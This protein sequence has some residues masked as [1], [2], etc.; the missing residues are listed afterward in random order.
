MEKYCTKIA[1][2]RRLF[3]PNDGNNTLGAHNHKTPQ[4]SETNEFIEACRTSVHYFQKKY[5]FD[6]EKMIPIE[7]EQLSKWNESPVDCKQTWRWESLDVEHSYVPS[8]YHQ[9]HYGTRMTGFSDESGLERDPCLPCTPYKSTQLYNCSSKSI[10]S[11]LVKGARVPNRGDKM[12]QSPKSDFPAERLYEA[13]GVVNLFS[14]WQPKIKRSSHPGNNKIDDHRSKR[15]NLA[16]PEERNFQSSL[17]NIYPSSTDELKF[18][19]IEKF[20]GSTPNL[21]SDRKEFQQSV[22]VQPSRHGFWTDE[23][24][25]TRSSSLSRLKNHSVKRRPMSVNRVCGKISGSPSLSTHE[26]ASSRGTCRK[27]I[28]E[29]TKTDRPCCPRD[30]S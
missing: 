14:L 5:N 20:G 19:A 6:V 24:R 1:P 22:I 26:A 9:K 16:S 7:G 2:F 27:E 12:T 11:T 17:P 13:S 21:L 28:K 3:G 10:S 15:E 4:M 29:L 8:F 25:R 23:Y 30:Q 18:Q